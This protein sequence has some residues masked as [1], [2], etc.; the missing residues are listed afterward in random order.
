M[1]RKND[2]GHWINGTGEAIPPKYVAKID[3]DRDAMVERLFK[4]ANDVSA[5]LIKL[6]ETVESEV[7]KFLAKA[8]AEHNLVPNKGGNYWFTGFSG[9]MRVEVKIGKFI[10]F[11]ERLKFAKQ[12]IDNCLERWLEGADDKL[13][14]IVFDAF[15]TDQKGR[16]D[17]KRI[18]GLRKL[19][20][21]DREWNEAMDL[22]SKAI[23]ITG[24][25]TYVNFYRRT[26]PNGDWQSV[27]LDMARA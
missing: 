5:R 11:D 20:F 9:D 2:K 6:R 1:A 23:T 19:K 14:T 15:S 4:A 12:K 7:A 3:Q 21:D 8:A 13:K 22:I 16:I 24:S 17:T 18:L 10:N 26:A 25:K 27:C